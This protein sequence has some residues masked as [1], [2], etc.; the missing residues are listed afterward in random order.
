MQN[1][2]STP[3]SSCPSL[4]LEESQ[5]HSEGCQSNGYLKE[6]RHPEF[7][8]YSGVGGGGKRDLERGQRL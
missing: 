1:L 8:E 5:A 4:L 3:E 7:L 2:S 6:L